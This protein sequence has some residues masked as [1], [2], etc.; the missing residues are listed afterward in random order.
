MELKII[1]TEED[2]KKAVNYL[3]E[4]GDN[5]NFE[6]NPELIE[7]FELI[8]KLIEL[9]DNEHYPIEKGNPIEIIKLKMEYMELKQK[10]L[11]PAIGSKGLVSDVLNKKRKLS[12]KMIRELSKLLNIS[13]EI[14]NTEY[15]LSLTKFKEITKKIPVTEKAIFKFSK[16]LWSHIENFSNL[17]SQRGSIFNVS[18]V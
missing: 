10:D 18:R 2:Y 14:L 15:E 11:I 6:N 9:Y 3:E 16:A 5:P 13:Q 1:K 8:E 17:V 12:K 4:L 7:K